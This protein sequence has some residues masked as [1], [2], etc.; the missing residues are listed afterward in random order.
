MRYPYNRHSIR[1]AL[2][3]LRYMEGMVHVAWRWRQLGI[4]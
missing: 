4:T 3:G 1:A 2:D